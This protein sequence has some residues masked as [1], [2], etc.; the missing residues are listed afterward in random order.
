M[1]YFDV[2][3]TVIENNLASNIRLGRLS[4]ERDL[5]CVEYD[6]TCFAIAEQSP[7]P[8][9]LL[10]VTLQQNTTD[11]VQ[12]AAESHPDSEPEVGMYP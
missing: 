2:V 12:E 7:E 3:P 1:G 11:R 4:T 5:Q 10:R 6:R 8:E 9:A